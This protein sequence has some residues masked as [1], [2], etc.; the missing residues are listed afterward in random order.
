MTVGAHELAGGLTGRGVV[1]LGPEGIGPAGG[2]PADQGSKGKGEGDEAAEEGL[3]GTT[4]GKNGES[5]QT[6][7]RRDRGM[8]HQAHQ[9]DSPVRKSVSVHWLTNTVSF[10]TATWARARDRGAGPRTTFP[11]ASY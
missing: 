11:V 9:G 3:K 10:S 6:G 2:G 1:L 4:H 7:G 8:G 5:R